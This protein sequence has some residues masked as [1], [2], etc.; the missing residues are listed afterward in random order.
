MKVRKLTPE[1]MAAELDRLERELG[2]S[3]AEFYDRYRA[4]QMG[5]STDVIHWA[6]LCYMALRQ[7][8]LVAPGPVHS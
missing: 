8:I 7:G 1:G 5:D 4:G 6:G 3:A 2:M